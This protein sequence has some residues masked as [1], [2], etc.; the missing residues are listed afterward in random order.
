[1]VDLLP[2]DS[3]AHGCLLSRCNGGHKSPA[4]LLHRMAVCAR[5]VPSYAACGRSAIAI[6]PA[7][8]NV[9]SAGV[10]VLLHAYCLPA[11]RIF[12]C[13]MH[14]LA[15]RMMDIR[16]NIFFGVIGP[17]A[18]VLRH[19]MSGSART[20]WVCCCSAGRVCCR[21]GLCR[22]ALPR[23]GCQHHGC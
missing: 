18:T 12:G 1:M 5:Y 9:S 8:C 7:A 21:T 3:V 2:A 22:L 19:K 16:S 6:E 17:G 4:P 23:I 15:C 13:R 20:P 14:D 10:L 11:F